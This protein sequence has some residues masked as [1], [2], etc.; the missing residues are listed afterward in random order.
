MPARALRCFDPIFSN[1]IPVYVKNNKCP[2]GHCRK[3]CVL[4][5]GV[6]PASKLHARWRYT[7]ET[8]NA[9]KGIKTHNSGH[10]SDKK[11]HA[12]KT[13]NARKGIVASAGALAR[14]VSPSSKLHAKWRYTG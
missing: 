11:S 14:G 5:R 8:I 3:S 6:S 7:G 4:A 10:D 2:Q 12:L 9:R 13:I 1:F